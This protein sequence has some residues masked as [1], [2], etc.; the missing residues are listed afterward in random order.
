MKQFIRITAA[1]LA[2]LLCVG[3]LCAC[4]RA[5]KDATVR[6]PLAE[7]P[8]TLDPQ[9]ATS[10]SE[11]CVVA[12]CFEGMMKAT[13]DGEIVP[14]AAEKVSVSSDGLNYL[15]TLKRDAR[16]HINTNHEDLPEITTRKHYYEIYQIFTGDYTEMENAEGEGTHPVLTN[17]VWGENGMFPDGVSIGDPVSQDILQA[18]READCVP[19]RTIE[20]LRDIAYSIVG[21]P[22]KVEF[23]DRIVGIIE[24]RDGTI[25]DVVRQIKEIK[26]PAVYKKKGRRRA[27]G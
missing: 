2:A 17:V 7:E 10:D 20:E 27:N 5:E 19:L 24:A 16:W 21:E 14:A 23:E 12:N 9:I 25:I 4:S 26:Q 13:A 1:L 3:S 15:F 18:L 6:L 11:R 22:D 8:H